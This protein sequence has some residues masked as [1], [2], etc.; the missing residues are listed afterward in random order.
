MLLENNR[1]YGS[2]NLKRCNIHQNKDNSQKLANKC[3]SNAESLGN[4][5][6]LVQ[7]G[8]LCIH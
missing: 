7:F 5:S 1:I 6:N 2:T 3:S 4:I 8:P